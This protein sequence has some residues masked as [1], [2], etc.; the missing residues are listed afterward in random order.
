MAFKYWLLV[1][2]LAHLRYCHIHYCPE[3][4]YLLSFSRIRKQWVKRDVPRYRQH[5]M[6]VRLTA[7]V[8]CEIMRMT[9][10]PTAAV[11]KHGN[12]I[13]NPAE[14]EWIH[15]CVWV[16]SWPGYR[17]SICADC[18]QSCHRQMGGEKWTRSGRGIEGNA[19]WTLD[20]SMIHDKTSISKLGQESLQSICLAC[21]K[22][23]R[24]VES[25]AVASLLD[26]W[27]RGDP[28]WLS[29]SQKND[30]ML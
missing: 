1:C 10:R 11:L 2:G 12:Q 25:D 29:S 15:Q 6:T 26:A 22:P 14:H 18:H 24:P 8:L 5:G 16:H 3:R 28:T 7:A 17:L 19:I 23:A 21:R 9:V 30:W 20:R 27:E 4:V 13:S